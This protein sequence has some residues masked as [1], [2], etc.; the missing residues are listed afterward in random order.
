[1][2]NTHFILSSENSWSAIYRTP[3]GRAVYKVVSTIPT[4]AGRDV[5]ISTVIPSFINNQVAP[6]DEDVKHLKDIFAHLA[7]IEYRTIRSSRIR[8]GDLDVPANGTNG[9]FKEDGR[10]FLGRNRIF[11]GPDG[12]EYTWRMGPKICKLFVNDSAKTPVA[13]FHRRKL[14]MIGGARPASLEIFT[15]GKDMVNLIVVTGVYV[16]K[17]RKAKE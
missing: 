13:C 2:S 6:E 3:E 8:M 12:K 1:M 9:Y 16:A 7:T 11:T 14:S 10:G 15:A 4:L 5:K 17:L